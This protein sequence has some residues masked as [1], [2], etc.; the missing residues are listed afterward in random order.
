MAAGP[1]DPISLPDY[2]T[3]RRNLLAVLD[4]GLGHATRS[5]ALCRHLEAR[6]EVV[7]LAAAGNARRFL[8]Q[9]FPGRKVVALPAYNIHYGHGSLPLSIAGQLPH[10]WKTVR[11]EQ[12]AVEALVDRLGIDRIISDSRFGAWSAKIPSVFLS[13][14]LH[15]IFG[16][17]FAAR[18]YRH[19][20]RHFSSTWVPDFSGPDRL[21]GQ[22]SDPKGWE[23]VTYIGQL[24]RFYDPDIPSAVETKAYDTFSLLSGP[25]PQRSRLEAYLLGQLATRPGHHLLVRGIPGPWEEGQRGNCRILPYTTSAATLHHLL[26]AGTIICRSGY[27]TLM[28]LVALNRSQVILIPT[29]GQTEQEYLA[30]RAEQRGWAKCFSQADWHQQALPL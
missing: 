30:H 16:F 1:I 2:R 14:Q 18:I 4:W 26:T 27:S 7:V 29:P 13:H 19:Y 5:I 28:D 25:E 11:R 23:N 10:I 12:E 3:G 9:S 20:L 6:G 21:S 22:L 8:Q 15:P 24:S 17:A